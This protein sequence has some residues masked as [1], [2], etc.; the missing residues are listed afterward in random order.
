[1]FQK[2]LR[3]I[4]NPYRGG[5]LDLDPKGRAMAVVPYA[6]GPGQNP[7]P[8]I[9][10]S[11]DIEATKA[12]GKHLWKISFEPVEVLCTS[13]PEFGYYRRAVNEGHILAADKATALACGLTVEEFKDPVVLLHE[14]RARCVEG[15]AAHYGDTPCACASDALPEL[16]KGE[17][18]PAVPVPDAPE[19]K[20]EHPAAKALPAASTKS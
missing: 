5:F 19:T 18:K 4:A 1:M 9:G 20:P 13:I 15:W 10:A 3:V 17:G 7:P 14:D 2:K 12:E 11:P 8:P 6:S 16:P